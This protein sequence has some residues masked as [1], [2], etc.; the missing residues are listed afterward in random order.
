[1]NVFI[2][3]KQHSAVVIYKGSITQCC[4]FETLLDNFMDEFGDKNP[5]SDEVSKFAL[6]YIEA[7]LWEKENIPMKTHLQVTFV[8]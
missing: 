6:N 3:N 2:A 8:I 5:S 4:K 7:M 1:M